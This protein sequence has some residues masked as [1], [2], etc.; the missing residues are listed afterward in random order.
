MKNKIKNIIVA[1]SFTLCGIM[2]GCGTTS[3]KA[4]Q[5]YPLKIWPENRNGQM[6]TWKVVDE[7]TGVNYII[8]ALNWNSDGSKY[9][10]VCITPRL[11]ADGSLY[12]SK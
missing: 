9:D 4:E 7:S 8:V 3:I 1:I 11:N 10:G 5:T 6:E 2:V 12:T